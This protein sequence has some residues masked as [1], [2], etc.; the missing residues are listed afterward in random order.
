[1]IDICGGAKAT[2]AALEIAKEIL[3]LD[4]VVVYVKEKNIAALKCY[5]KAGFSLI[6]N[7]SGIIQMLRQL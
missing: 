7:R 1:M 2:V 6:D 4:T 3:L 5:D